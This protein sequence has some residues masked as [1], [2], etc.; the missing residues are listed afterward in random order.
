[1]A[2]SQPEGFGAEA[3]AAARLQA[4]LDDGYIV[5]LPAHKG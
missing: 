1:L 2:Q 5:P 3:V 4:W